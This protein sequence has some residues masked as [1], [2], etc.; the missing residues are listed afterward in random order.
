MK[1]NVKI[2]RISQWVSIWIA[3][4]LATVRIITTALGVIDPKTDNVLRILLYTF[5]LYCAIGAK[6]VAKLYEKF[7]P[8][9]VLEREIKE[10]NAMGKKEERDEDTDNS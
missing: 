8:E 6:V 2:L 4:A 5:L 3:L 10:A 9:D 7:T 1:N